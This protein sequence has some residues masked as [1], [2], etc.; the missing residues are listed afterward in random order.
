M[1]EVRAES[2]SGCYGGETENIA[3]SIIVNVVCSSYPLSLNKKQI[4]FL[5]DES[6]SM[7]DT[8]PAIKNSLFATRNA[9]LKLLE[10]DLNILDEKSKDDI[11]T[12]ACNITLITFSNDAVCR[13]ESQNTTDSFSTAVNKIEASCS[14]NMGAGLLMAFAKKIPDC[15]TWII[16]LT[17]GNSN[18]GSYQT[19]SGFTDLKSQL[20]QHTKII[21]LGYTKQPDPDILSILGNMI[22]IESE[23]SIPEIFGNITG[24]I[25]TCYG[26]DAKITLPSLPQP[27]VNP[28]DIIIVSDEK[29]SPSRDIIGTSNIGCLFNE[30]RFIYGHLPWGNNMKSD[31]NLYTGL[32]GT[33]S[34]YN[35]TT[36]SEINIEFKIERGQKIPENIFESYFEASKSRILLGYYH[37]KKEGN[38]KQYIKLIQK[39]LLDWKHPASTQHKEEILRIFSN[40]PSDI[41][42]IG[43]ATSARTQ[44]NYTSVSRHTTTLQRQ[45]SESVQTEYNNIHSLP[46]LLPLP[47]LPPILYS[48]SLSI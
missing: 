23:E 20:P 19:V 7:I 29:Q 13:F 15:A 1:C 36:K 32:T 46:D 47:P 6:G 12:K 25:V 43:I 31:I 26:L 27:T 5:V 21:P 34:Y 16:L 18:K 42:T 4:I 22:Y 40:N 39:K 8:I 45:I 33:L 38:I 41:S 24:E 9:I 17:D 28:N 44:T 3:D 30:R 14:T 35:I 10:H 11:F 37:N 48:F 2:Y